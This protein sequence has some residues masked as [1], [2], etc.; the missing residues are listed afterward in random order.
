MGQMQDPAGARPY[1]YESARFPEKRR[2]DVHKVVVATLSASAA[3][4]L[5]DVRYCVFITM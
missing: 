1:P 2:K 3:F 4:S 5:L